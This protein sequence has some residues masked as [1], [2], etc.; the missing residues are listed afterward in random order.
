MKR[1]IEGPTMPVPFLAGCYITSWGNITKSIAFFSHQKGPLTQGGG[2]CSAH[3]W[4]QR[5][6]DRGRTISSS[7]SGWSINWVLEQLWLHKPCLKK[8][9]LKTATKANNPRNEQRQVGHCEC[10][11]SLYIINSMSAR[12]TECSLISKITTPTHTN[13]F[14][15]HGKKTDDWWVC[16]DNHCFNFHFW[17]HDLPLLLW[18]SLVLFVFWC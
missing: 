3:L 5:L 2:G 4:S 16:K 12:A 1:E 10:E 13:D 18:I 7:R 8:Q 17:S 14:S 6:G 15:F 9:N 11:V